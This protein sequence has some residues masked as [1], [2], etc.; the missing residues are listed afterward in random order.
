MRQRHPAVKVLILTQ[1]DNQEYILRTT[2]T[3]LD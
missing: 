3:M 1:H 2:S